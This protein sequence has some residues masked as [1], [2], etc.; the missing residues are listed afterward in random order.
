MS[1]E[2]IHWNHPDRAA[3]IL[4]DEN[5]NDGK[6][7]KGYAGMSFSRGVA[8]HGGIS[9]YEVHIALFASGPS[10]KKNFESDL[11]TS[12]VDIV[13]TILSIHGLPIPNSMDGR[14]I[15]EFLSGKT[16]DKN[17]KPKKETITTS[18]EIPG[19]KYILTL[20]RTILGKYQYVDFAKVE[21]R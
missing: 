2:S 5:W 6:N 7:D 1:F 14:V 8:G 15:S 3:D 10:F 4:V 18:A 11:P 9:P 12:N 13:P 21:R 17:L 19:F 20:N 16:D